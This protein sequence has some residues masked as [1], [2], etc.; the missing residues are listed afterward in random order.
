MSIQNA[1]DTALRYYS[2]IQYFEHNRHLLN[3][4][5]EFVLRDAVMVGLGYEAANNACEIDLHFKYMMFV[6]E[7]FL[8][9]EDYG[10]NN[11]R[12]NFDSLKYNFLNSTSSYFQLCTLHPEE[13]VDSVCVCYLMNIFG[14]PAFFLDVEELDNIEKFIHEHH[15]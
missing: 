14:A 1:I 15:Y 5:K 2:I 11:F 3:N 10:N 13:V 4:D 7:N 12:A 6:P 8:S 9:V